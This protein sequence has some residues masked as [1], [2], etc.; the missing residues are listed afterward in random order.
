MCALVGLLCETVTLVHGQ[1]QGTGTSNDHGVP[2]VSLVRI[3]KKPSDFYI[4]V[5]TAHTIILTTR[6]GT[7]LRYLVLHS[8]TRIFGY[9]RCRRWRSEA[10][11][12]D[13]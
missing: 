11:P 7:D 4:P 13:S 8:S 12:C 9:L 2:G 3:L 10:W 1:E 6:H 5:A